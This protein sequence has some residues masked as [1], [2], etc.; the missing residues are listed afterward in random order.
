MVNVSYYSI[1]VI[2]KN[3]RILCFSYSF[4]FHFTN[5]YMPIKRLISRLLNIILIASRKRSMANHNGYA[6]K[7]MSSKWKD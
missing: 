3:L 1:G 2:A 6:K 4:P 5:D 7:A